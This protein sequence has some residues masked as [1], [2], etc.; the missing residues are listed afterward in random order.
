M[1]QLQIR[2]CE[3]FNLKEQIMICPDWLTAGDKS[4][5]LFPIPAEDFN[6]DF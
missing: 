2:F 4:L 6:T 3:E 5:G 1:G